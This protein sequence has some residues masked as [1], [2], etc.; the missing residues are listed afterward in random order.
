MI[1]KSRF[2]FSS[3]LLLALV[4]PAVLAWGTQGHQVIALLAE[5]Q[6]SS[7]A[8]LEVTRLLALEP[9]ET[10]ASI[11]TW[12]DEQR[13][14]QTAARHYVNFPRDSCSYDANRD[15]PD[16]KCVVEAINRQAQILQSTTADEKRLTALKYLVHLVG[17]V[18]QPLHAGYQDDKGGNTY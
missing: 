13:S 6:L 12:A 11:S 1:C 15:C 10:L 18:H 9:G 3:F 14:P 5:Q 16:G 2:A 4:P 7:Q 17:D 8:R